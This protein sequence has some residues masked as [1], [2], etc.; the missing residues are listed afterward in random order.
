MPIVDMRINESSVKY[1]VHNSASEAEKFR[2]SREHKFFIVHLPFADSSNNI[3]QQEKIV[4][5]YLDKLEVIEFINFLIKANAYVREY[6]CEPEEVNGYER[7][8]DY[9]KPGLDAWPYRGNDFLKLTNIT[10][11]YHDYLDNRYDVELLQL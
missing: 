3:I 4:F 2:F 10:V 1:S 5:T 9:S 6:N 7:W 11:F 8:C